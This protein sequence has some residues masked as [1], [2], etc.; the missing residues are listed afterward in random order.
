MSDRASAGVYDDQSGKFLVDALKADGANLCAY[1]VIPDD[2][3][4]IAK[5]IREI[6][7]KHAPSV[8]LMSGRQVRRHGM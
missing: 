4:A 3:A 8:L 6:C 7:G 2:K 1:Q 5:T